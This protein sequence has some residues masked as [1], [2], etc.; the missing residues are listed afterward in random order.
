MS[1]HNLN[2]NS[3]EYTTPA[4]DTMSKA[5]A[6]NLADWHIASVKHDGIASYY[7]DS[8]WWRCPGSSGIYLGA[9]IHDGATADEETFAEL[10]AVK[11]LWG[12]Q[13]FGVYDCWGT[14]DLSEIGFHFIV[15]N[16]WYLRPPAPAPALNL[17]A[18][19][20]I[21]IAKT[22][23]QLADFEWATWEGFEEPADA[24][25]AFRGRQ[26]FSQHP[27]GTLEEE[28]MYYLNARLDGK[29]V[30]GVIIHRTVDMMGVYGIST[31]IPYR[32]RGYASALMRFAVA[33]RPDLPMSVFPDPVSV[34]V[35]SVL[36]FARAGEIAIWNSQAS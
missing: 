34:P 3:T 5:M 19:V 12:A 8:L 31:L 26:T 22:L 20:T 4:N 30:A 9:I 15:K 18:G 7:T 6:L 29:V 36:G 11:D 33:L 17:P 14:R 25:E 24:E 35:Y 27:A 23:Q 32:R 10:R 2:T 13:S 21:E 1:T 28:G 16:P